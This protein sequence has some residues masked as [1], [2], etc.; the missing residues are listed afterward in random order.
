MI[1][2]ILMEIILSESSN[3]LMLDDMCSL[4]ENSQ[5]HTNHMV[6]LAEPQQ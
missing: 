6:L 3:L 5:Q 2:Q 4:L 1:V